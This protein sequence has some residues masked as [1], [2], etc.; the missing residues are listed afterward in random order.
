MKNKLG[1][2]QQRVGEG[3]ESSSR[4]HFQKHPSLKQANRL[5]LKVNRI[6]LD[7]S[8]GKRDLVRDESLLD[9]SEVKSNL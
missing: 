5:N 9:K 2:R 7:R 3:V 1:V 8:L 4:F 6:G